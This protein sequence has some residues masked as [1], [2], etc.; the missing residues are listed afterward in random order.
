MK[1]QLY[2][3]SLFFL[4]VLLFINKVPD[5][6]GSDCELI[7]WSSDNVWT[8]LWE[9]KYTIGSLIMMVLGLVCYYRINYTF[10]G[11]GGLSEEVEKIEDQNF[12]HLTFLATY[13]I[14]L[15]TFDLDFHLEERRNGLMF[16]LVLILIGIIYLRTNMYYTNPTLA[17]F[18]FRI[19]KADTLNK[20]NIILI[21]KCRIQESETISCRPISDNVYFAYKVTK[22]QR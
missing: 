2:I 18:G 11:A 12:E 17:V 14:P 15:L 20:K 8:C 5:C 19:Y 1:L 16:L 22:K 3:V 6:W 13:I 10:S 9:N 7:C 21:T 4:F